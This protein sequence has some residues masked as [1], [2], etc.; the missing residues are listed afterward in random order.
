MKKLFSIL[1]ISVLLFSFA[2]CGTA[3]RNQQPQN[4][5]SLSENPGMDGEQQIGD[6]R[7]IQITTD[8]GNKIIVLLNNSPAADSFYRQLPLSVSIED[9]AGSEKIFY[10]SE[11]LNT[12]DTPLAK[13][14]SGTLAYYAPWGNIALFYQECRGAGDLYGLGEVVT[15]AEFIS[16]L[17]GEIQI[18]LVDTVSVSHRE[19]TSSQ[20]AQSA[21]G[22]STER[23]RPG[24]PAD[25]GNSE[26]IAAMKMKVQVGSNTFTATLEENTAADT[27]M[28]K[29]KNAPVTIRMR[30]YSGFEKVGSLETSLPASD[31]QITT[32]SG[33]I[34]LYNG[35]QIV[36]FYGSNSWSYT[37][38]G[39]IDDLTGWAEALG[40]GDVTVTFSLK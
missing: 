29:I 26:E 22:P 39:K 25:E 30:D 27:F 36:V 12:I 16:E 24:Q 3:Q 32:Q 21:A 28:Q 19:N 18:E 1:M 14:P 11:E 8:S 5:F 15:G 7:E 20:S 33:D 4:T 2:A 9:Y 35:E 31:R 17:T 23:K 34:V 38:L 40:N 10:P 13:G 6:S 37:R